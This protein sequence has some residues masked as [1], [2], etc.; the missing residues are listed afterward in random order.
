MKH[1]FSV[2]IQGSQ[3]CLDYYRQNDA[4]FAYLFL[5]A[6][7]FAMRISFLFYLVARTLSPFFQK[8]CFFA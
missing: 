8:G 1:R 7:R 6:K 5:C 4:I 2:L 3:I